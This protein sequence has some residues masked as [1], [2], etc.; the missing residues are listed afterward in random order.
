MIRKL[1][2]VAVLVL[3]AASA[4]AERR[5]RQPYFASG[6]ISQMHPSRGGYRIWIDGARYPF[7]VPSSQFRNYPFHVGG[8]VNLGGYY[9]R[10]G[11]YDYY[12]FDCYRDAY[13]R[14]HRDD[15][16]FKSATVRG[17]VES[18]DERLNT[19]V[20]IAEGNDSPV[21]VRRGNDRGLGALRVGDYLEV[22]GEWTRTGYFDAVR[23][24]YAE[25]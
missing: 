6:S 23:I 8:T 15:L 18:I 13:N 4:F 16:K 19:F 2:L 17:K 20:I 24:D 1:V 7:F 5:P 10:R 21:T 11:Y 14:D 9:N 3:V 22:D 25:R 12:C